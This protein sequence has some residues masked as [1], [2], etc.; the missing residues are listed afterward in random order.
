[1]AGKRLAVVFVTRPLVSNSDG[2]ERTIESLASVISSA[3]APSRIRVSSF[4]SSPKAGAV[5]SV[6]TPVEA[7][8]KP[9]VRRKTNCEFA[10]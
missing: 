5:T 2:S 6:R 1:M 9:G 3:V 10:P 4:E 7:T 8:K